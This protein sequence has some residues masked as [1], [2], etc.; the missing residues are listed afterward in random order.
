MATYRDSTQV[1]RAPFHRT[2]CMYAV[3]TP[4][5]VAFALER[6]IIAHWDS[7]NRRQGEKLIVRVFYGDTDYP[8][9]EKVHKRPC[10]PGLDWNEEFETIGAVGR[11]MGEKHIPLLLTDP[12]EHGGGGI[13][14]GCIVRMFVNQEEIYR[15]PNY[16]N[17]LDTAVIRPCKIEQFRFEVIAADEV[18][19][20]RFEDEDQ[21]KAWIAFMCGET[22]I[23]PCGTGE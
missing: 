6:A 17:P 5:V 22:H 16:R 10:D 12:R 21:A 15:H 8:D 18:V 9:F 20:A 23:N 11:S 14:D 3:Q 4:D 2:L 19:H 13:L 7:E 1:R